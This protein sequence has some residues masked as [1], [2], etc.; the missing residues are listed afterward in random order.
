[1]IRQQFPGRQR[2]ARQRRKT[3]IRLAQNPP[4]FFTQFFRMR[5]HQPDR[6][7]V[8]KSLRRPPQHPHLR[9]FD[10]DFD[11]FRIGMS[12]TDGIDRGRLDINRRLVAGFIRQ[13]RRGIA[14]N[15]D[16]KFEQAS[17]IRGRLLQH[18]AVFQ[19]IQFD[20]SP[21]IVAVKGVRIDRHAPARRPNAPR[22][23]E[24]KETR[25]SAQIDKPIPRRKQPRDGRLNFQFM[26]ANPVAVDVN[27]RPFPAHPLCIARW[28]RHDR[29]FGIAVGIPAQSAP[30][31]RNAAHHPN[32]LRPAHAAKYIGRLAMNE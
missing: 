32:H 9:P 3:I 1:M 31:P 23:H 26:L 6:P 19:I 10:I 24:H 27:M 21:Q 4:H 28:N 2:L 12:G 14:G 5:F 15:D 25:I 8:L 16:D 22:A 20:L 18:R 29:A 11:Q 30:H 13:M 7:G 17:T